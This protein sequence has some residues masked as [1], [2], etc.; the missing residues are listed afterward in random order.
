M[1]PNSIPVR[2]QVWDTGALWLK[3][4][5]AQWQDLDVHMQIERANAIFQRIPKVELTLL[6]KDF[7]RKVLHATVVCEQGVPTTPP[8]RYRT[9][10]TLYETT[11]T[12]NFGESSTKPKSAKKLLEKLIAALSEADLS[13]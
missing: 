6:V 1:F 8:M 7:E 13:E 4:A 3:T 9:P 12:N 10:T 2:A 11:Q 5:A